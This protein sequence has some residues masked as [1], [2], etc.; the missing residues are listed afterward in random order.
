[1]K[2]ILDGNTRRVGAIFNEIDV[3]FTEVC[4]AILRIAF[5][6]YTLKGY[7]VTEPASPA[8]ND[9][10]LVQADA[11][12]WGIEAEKNHIIAW[13]G[14]AWELIPFKIT[15]INEALQFMFFDAANIAIE[16]IAG[17]DAGNVQEAIELITQA[18]IA[19]S[20]NIPEGSGSGS[21]SGSL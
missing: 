9:C 20:I 7:A 11:T 17:L 12:I 21:G 14:A 4:N 13:D 18:L 16:P 2:K 15:E 1:M 6:G 19:A 10:Y 3:N 5:P 8:L